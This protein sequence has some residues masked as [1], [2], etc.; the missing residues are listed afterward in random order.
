MQR[1]LIKKI[2]KSQHTDGVRINKAFHS[3]FNPHGNSFYVPRGKS[4][5]VT[6][7]FNKKSF[8]ANYLHENPEKD[9]AMESLRFSKELKDEFKEISPDL[10]GHFS[11]MLGKDINEFI[12]EF[13][14][15]HPVERSVYADFSNVSINE[16][17]DRPTLAKLWGYKDYHAI[18]KGVV[19][20][21][22]T[23]IIILFV[24]QEKQAA[25]AQYNDYID[26]NLLFWE[27]EEK[28]GSDQRI[29]N[30]GKNGD[31]IH[32]FFREIH[33]SPFIYH[34]MIHLKEHQINSKQASEFIFEI[35]Q[36]TNY[37]DVFGDIQS[38]EIEFTPLDKT[39]KESLIKSRIGQGL[40]RKRVIALWGKCAV[41]GLSSISLLK[42]SHIK[43]WRDCTN[44]ERLDPNNGLLLTPNLDLLFDTGFITFGADGSIQLSK[45]LHEIDSHLLG[46]KKTLR[47][48]KNPIG[49][50]DFMHFHRENVFLG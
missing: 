6:V 37:A 16:Q 36:L 24:T 12:F 11:I 50:Q 43:P 33:H 19:T 5:D 39:E 18:S 13:M 40:F 17:Y 38:K 29:I 34:G 10:H 9:L 3:V 22:G 23:N 47:L 28:H 2:K 45:K 7:L 31:Q 4:R 8:K 35:A 21:R 42:A 44:Q 1:G 48:R 26:D 27:G 41:T 46:V 15:D 14:Q 49:I 25:L 32:L 20:P 30:A